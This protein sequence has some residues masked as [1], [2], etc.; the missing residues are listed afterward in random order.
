VIPQ[1][2]EDQLLRKLRSP[3]FGERFQ[4]DSWK[5]LFFEALERAFGKQKEKLDITTLIAKKVTKTASKQLSL[6]GRR[7]EED[8][9]ENDS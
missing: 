4:K 8:E 7:A 9:P 5:C 2:R 1:E 6:F 3:L